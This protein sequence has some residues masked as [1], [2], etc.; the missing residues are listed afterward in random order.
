LSGKIAQ[1]KMASSDRH[2]KNNKAMVFITMVQLLLF[3][4]MQHLIS[5]TTPYK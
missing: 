5:K 1:Y 4:P 2:K 3:S